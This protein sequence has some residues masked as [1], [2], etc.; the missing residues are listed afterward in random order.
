M[1]P[2]ETID[3]SP[4]SRKTG[5]TVW[6]LPHFEH[7]FTSVFQ[8]SPIIVYP[9]LD[10]AR[11]KYDFINYKSQITNPKQITI[12][13]VQNKKNEPNGLDIGFDIVIL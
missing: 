9:N 4:V 6:H 8:S 5:Q 3:S 11:T 1:R 13:N 2:R 10:L 7:L 12:P